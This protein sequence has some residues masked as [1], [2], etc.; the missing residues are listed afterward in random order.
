M[1]KKAH[2][3]LISFLSLVGRKNI[4]WLA[5]VQ[6]RSCKQPNTGLKPSGAILLLGTGQILGGLFPF[7]ST[8]LPAIL[9]SRVCSPKTSLEGPTKEYHYLELIFTLK[10][11]K[12]EIWAKE[13]SQEHTGEWHPTEI[14]WFEFCRSTEI[15]IRLNIHFWMKWKGRFR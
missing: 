4:N 9:P 12:K 15:L 2:G 14:L 7:P 13:N 5:L 6:W 11:W 1:H 8:S 3:G 10:D